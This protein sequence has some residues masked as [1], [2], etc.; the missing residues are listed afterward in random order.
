MI[1]ILQELVT[2]IKG[3]KN[4]EQRVF[5]YG[6]D[7][8]AAVAALNTISHSFQNNLNTYPEAMAYARKRNWRKRVF[9]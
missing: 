6:K 8:D 9:C 2:I 7:I 5:Y 3:M 1:W 4:F